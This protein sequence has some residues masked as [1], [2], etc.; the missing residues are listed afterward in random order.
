MALW[1]RLTIMASFSLW[2]HH[3]LIHLIQIFVSSHQHRAAPQGERYASCC[4]PAYHGDTVSHRVVFSAVL[5]QAFEFLRCIAPHC[6]DAIGHSRQS[7]AG[8]DGGYL[9]K[10]KNFISFGRARGICASE[11]LSHSECWEANEH[12]LE[13][14]QMGIISVTMAMSWHCLRFV[15]V[16]Y[17]AWPCVRY[18]AGD[19]S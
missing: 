10:I 3:L 17:P 7:T 13:H 9:N 1:T 6:G 18:G 8:E 12:E 5:L 16:P 2:C 15:R 19:P 11:C 14:I 4:E